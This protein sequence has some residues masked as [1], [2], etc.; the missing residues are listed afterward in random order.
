[1]DISTDAKREAWIEKRDRKGEIKWVT[2]TGTKDLI[3]IDPQA[4]KDKDGDVLFRK[5]HSVGKDGCISEDNGMVRYF[6]NSFVH[7]R[8]VGEIP[9]TYQKK[10]NA[11]LATAKEGPN[12]TD[13]RTGFVY[14]TLDMKPLKLKVPGWERLGKR[15]Y[16]KRRKEGVEATARLFTNMF[17]AK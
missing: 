12:K 3:A 9:E 17:F 11:W 16:E 4:V 7:Q 5:I 10:L 15:E 1:M 2:L 8:F 6:Y 13:P 14:P